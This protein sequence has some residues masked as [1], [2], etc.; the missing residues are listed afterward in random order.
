MQPV[1]D[2]FPT[3]ELTTAIVREHA[4]V[5]LLLRGELDMNGV[6]ETRAP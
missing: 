2:R 1:P 5:R 4:G 3:G 6:L